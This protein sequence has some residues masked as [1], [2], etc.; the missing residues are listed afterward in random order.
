MASVANINEVLE[1][2][3]ALEIECV[4][5]LYLNAYVPALQVGGQIVRFL[6]EHLGN[7]IPSPALLGPIGNRFRR[8]VK[9]FATEHEIP[10]LRLG[11]PDR[12][13]WDDRKLDQVRPYLEAAEREG[14]YGVVA[15]VA[16]Q[17]FQWVFSARNRAGPGKVVSF[18]YFREERRV[19]IYYFYILDPDFGPG[20]IKIGTY[21]PYSAKVWLNGHE[22]AKRQAT[23]VGIPFTALSN[24]FASTPDQGRLQ[25]VCDSFAP[26]HVQAFFDRWITT[27][28]TPLTAEDRAAGYWWELSMRQVEVSRTLVLDDPRRARLFFE[29]LVQDNVGIG[30]PEEVSLVFAR[31]LRRPTRHPYQTRIFSA[32]TEVRIDFRY[33]HSRV[34]Q[35]L[36]D[37]R[38]LRIEAVINKP[39]DLDIPAR[40]H[41]LPQLIDKAR[42]VNRRLLMIEQAGQS[43]AIGSALFERIHQPHI[44]GQRTGAL[45][46]GDQRAMALVGA[47][48]HLLPAVTGF[49]NKSLRG[50]VAGHLGQN[51]SQNQMSYDLRRLRLHGLIRRL[52]RTNTYVLTSE[53]IRVAIFYTKVKNRVLGPL[54]EADKPPAKLEIRRALITLDQAINDYT[55]AARLAPAT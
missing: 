38:A 41:N 7:P 6:R 54:L 30:R 9:A 1:G 3:V 14:R 37:G 23:R 33:K 35:Y 26:D 17:E 43:C 24:G 29:A 2:H 10:I 16:C 18:E 22:W 8:E 36:K 31:H 49:T 20:F 15:I 50:L 32:G 13:R 45:R 5:R 46:F 42:Q 40:L 25:A 48:C 21:A 19:G 53:G 55:S 11:K 12:S 47:L 52:P 28:P 51:Y 4:D 27:F 39:A 34:K 44:E